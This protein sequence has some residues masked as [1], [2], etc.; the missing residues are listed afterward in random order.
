MLLSSEESPGFVESTVLH[1]EVGMERTFGDIPVQPLCS[2]RVR[3]SRV[4]W[5]VS[6]GVLRPS[7]DG[8]SMH[9]LG[10]LVTGFDHPHIG[11][12]TSYLNCISWISTCAALRRVA[13]PPLLSTI[14]YWYKLAKYPFSLLFCSLDS[15]LCLSPC[16]RFFCL[17]IISAALHWAGC[18]TANPFLPWEPRSGH[19]SW[20][21]LSSTEQRTRIPAQPGG[22]APHA[23]QDAVGLFC[24]G[25]E[26][27]HGHLVTHPQPPVPLWALCLLGSS[28]LQAHC[29]QIC[30]PK[31]RH[32]NPYW[33]SK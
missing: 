33:A 30:I 13:L 28:G 9:T 7:S 20:M 15:F 8:N 32:I 2:S 26:L 3:H 22:H 31:L 11:K 27:A 6:S 1:Y 10:Q 4:L 16:V 24:R 23:A 17:L 21:C 12:T 5:G 14:W 19:R 18:S 29:F 25:T